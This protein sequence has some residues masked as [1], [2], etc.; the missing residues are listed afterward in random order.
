MELTVEDFVPYEE[1][2]IWR[3]QDAYFERCG[4]AAWAGGKIPYVATSNYAIARQHARLLVAH[5]AEL[6]RR[7]ALRAGEP[8]RILE[9]GSGL[10]LFA[11]NFIRA[12]ERG[13]GPEG[14]A[15]RGRLRYI[16]SDCSAASLR[17]VIQDERLAGLVAA[18]TIVPAVLDMRRPTELA[19]LDGRRL[20]EPL[21]A[22]IANYVV[23]V[24]TPRIVQKTP[25]GLAALR[26]K[27]VANVPDE[28]AA[29][30]DAARRW[31]ERSYAAA[32]SSDILKELELRYAWQPVDLEA[33]LPDS[34]DR[35]A[36]VETL[37]PFPLATV[38]YPDVFFAFAR[39]VKGLLVPGGLLL[40]ND[41][42]RPRARDLEGIR[43]RRAAH[44]GNSLAHEVN[45][46][47]FDAFCRVEGLA[48]LRTRRWALSIHTAAIWYRDS[49]PEELA[50][51]FR[52]THAKN[53]DGQD[54]L[55]LRA[56][57]MAAAAAEDHVG[58]VRH[59]S[60]CHRL[61]PHSPEILYHLGLACLHGGQAR[62]ALAWFRKG[63]R[64]PL[65]PKFDFEF[66]TGRALAIL[67]RHADARAVFEGAL[68]REEHPATRAN[69]AYVC[70]Q[71]Q[72][73]KNAYINYRRALQL[74]PEGPLAVTIMKKL[75]EQ[76]L[77]EDWAVETVDQE[78]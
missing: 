19:D 45:F 54:L 77:P 51:V 37:D 1:S 17:D 38:V 57:A 50:R 16:L 29:A 59:F 9:V 30:P 33:L 21:A 40:V 28:E 12:L 10:G 3:I 25:A 58:A 41:F 76:Y 11:I 34:R 75:V 36:L 32:S 42:G 46:A 22:V 69:L 14:R 24:L 62:R 13:S 44:Y 78:A 52:G 66:Q 6:E 43:D 18:G 8:V 53:E 64:L 68:A 61:D 65:D 48:L 74:D 31:L 49:V 60:R 4:K 72:D 7:G 67:E 2:V 23:C 56:A 71:L 5:V 47:L 39:A 63:L 26:V 20:E 35:S 70:E 73:Y 27:V 55:Q 15:V